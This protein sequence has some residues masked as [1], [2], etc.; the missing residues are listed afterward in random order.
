MNNKWIRWTN[1]RPVM[2]PS[3]GLH[4]LCIDDSNNI[5][6][7]SERAGDVNWYDQDR[8]ILA[9]RY[10]D[11]PKP[12]TNPNRHLGTR[13][14]NW[15]NCKFWPVAA[16]KPPNHKLPYFRIELWLQPD[17]EVKLEYHL[18][19]PPAKPITINYTDRADEA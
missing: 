4:L 2:Q 8:T 13:Y 19:E 17:G 18:P 7:S 6:H 14:W 15:T 16:L 3:D 10:V 9:W 12:V 5:V 11:Q 1:M